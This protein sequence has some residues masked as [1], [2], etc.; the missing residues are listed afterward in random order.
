M[1]EKMKIG[2]HIG[3]TDRGWA[4]GGLYDSVSAA[5]DAEHIIDPPDPCAVDIRLLMYV[6][7]LLKV[8]DVGDGKTVLRLAGNRWHNGRL[9]LKRVAFVVFGLGWSWGLLVQDLVER[10]NN[11]KFETLDFPEAFRH[12]Q[13]CRLAEYDL[14]LAQNAT[15]VAHFDDDCLPRTVARLGGNMTFKEVSTVDNVDKI[16]ENMG[17]CAAIIA[18]NQ[19]LY[20]VAKSVNEHVYLIPNGINLDE[21]YPKKLGYFVWQ[22][23]PL[24]GFVGNIK[25]QEKRDYKGYDITVQACHALGLN[26]KQA[27]YGNNQIPH[28]RMMADF[29]HQID[30][31]VLPTAGEGCSNSIMEALACGVPVITTRAAGY[32]G[33]RLTHCDNV[34]FCERTAASI[35]ACLEELIRFPGLTAMIGKNGRKFAEEHHDITN[36]AAEYQRVFDEVAARNKHLPPPASVRNGQVKILNYV[37]ASG[38]W[39]WGAVMGDLQ[40]WLVDEFPMVNVPHPKPGEDQAAIAK[41]YPE[42]CFFLQNINQIG[43]VPK[44][45]R[46]KT[47]SRLGGIMNFA[48]DNRAQQ[49]LEEMAGLAALIATNKELYDIGQAANPNT[50]LIPNGRNLR[51]WKPKPGKEFNAQKPVIGF[52]GNV[53]TAAKTKYK[54]YDLVTRVCRDMGLELRQMLYKQNQ[55]Q[56]SEMQRTFWHQIDLFILPTDGEGCNNAIMEALCCG[57]PVITTTTAGYHG[58]TLTDGESVIFCDKSYEGV[59]IAVKRMIGN[60]DLFKRLSLAGRKYAEAHHDVVKIAEQYRDV[61]RKHY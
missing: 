4:T 1:D 5:S 56:N 21:W 6:P 50:Y 9:P 35:Q 19:T 32:H 27:L 10:L 14:I 57:V 37:W 20:D 33:E 47:I 39:S 60:P 23:P 41:Q 28:E 52:I 17:K 15:Q 31:L 40:K 38:S 42:H 54:G 29:W 55:V 61:F 48:G 26:V 8:P 13:L 12:R 2:W 44:N 53:L 36:I 24:V 22:N 49:Y 11:Y 59:M 46:R 3:N 43:F 16:L 45:R 30:V 58:E 7:Q 25:T 34:L 18:T 51:A